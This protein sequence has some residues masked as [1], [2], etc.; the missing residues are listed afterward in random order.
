MA[1]HH[2]ESFKKMNLKEK[3]ATVIGFTLFIIF[4]IGIVFGIYFFGVAGI[5]A[6]LG[7]HYQSFWSLVIFVV[8]I[9]ILGLLADL[10]FSAMAELIVENISGQI[11]ALVIQGLFGFASNWL[12]LVTVDAFME[13][14]A[15]SYGTKF[16]MALLLA[17]L[18]LEFDDKKEKNEKRF[19]K[20]G[21]YVSASFVV[22]YKTAA[23]KRK[24]G[25]AVLTQLSAY[26]T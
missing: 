21:P 16:I 1:D 11:K 6:L 24:R 23:G 19:K 20:H 15:L 4:V 18:G 12:V 26:V 9:F 2:N 13:S 10:L 22:Y 3:T 17:V 25:Q 14:I 5:F 8:S 7:V